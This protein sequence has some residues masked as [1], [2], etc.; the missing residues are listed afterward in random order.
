MTDPAWVAHRN[1]YRGKNL[2]NHITDE[3]L[4]RIRDGSF[5]DLY[6]GDYWK[7]NGNRY[8]IVDINY[9]PIK[10]HL[11][12]MPDHGVFNCK[13]NDTSNISQGLLGS[14]IWTQY[15][16]NAFNIMKD[17][18]TNLEDIRVGFSQHIFN[19]VNDNGVTVGHVEIPNIKMSIPSQI[20]I[21]G[22]LSIGQASTDGH[23][24]ENGDGYEINQFS[25]FRLNSKLVKTDN[26]TRYWMRDILDIHNVAAIHFAGYNMTKNVLDQDTYIRPYFCIG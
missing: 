15:R 1:I 18:I 21:I 26:N 9:Y 11:V 7:I 6:V 12:I 22:S 25:A 20:H 24:Q 14:T 5:E 10:D 19:S 13:W 2:G 17:D 8:R 16:D 23:L 4:A 3:Q